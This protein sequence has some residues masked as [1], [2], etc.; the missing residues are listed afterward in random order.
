MGL[1]IKVMVLQSGHFAR[2]DF[3]NTFC[4]FLGICQDLREF[5]GKKKHCRDPGLFRAHAGSPDLNQGPSDLQSDAL[6]TELSR[7]MSKLGKIYCFI[8]N[9]VLSPLHK[10]E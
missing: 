8:F 1:S 6:P 3:K 10:F 4:F 9:D 2:N 7:L 5:I